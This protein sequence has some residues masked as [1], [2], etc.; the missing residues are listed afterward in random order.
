MEQVVGDEA[1]LGERLERERSRMTH[2]L[3]MQA[4][5]GVLPD[6]ADR[7]RRAR[8]ATA[9]AWMTHIAASVGATW[10]GAPADLG[11]EIDRWFAQNGE[12][13]EVIELDL[14]RRIDDGPIAD[15]EMR[16]R[17]VDLGAAAR[18]LMEG[19]GAVCDPDRDG[20]PGFARRAGARLDDA[21]D[22]IG[23]EVAE[24]RLSA[25]DDQR[26]AESAEL[27]AHVR[28]VVSGLEA[29]LPG[30]PAGPAPSA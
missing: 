6:E 23:S 29:V 14:A 3:F 13:L 22:L 1:G 30:F 11:G 16:R 25:P 10:P 18:W 20:G 24:A 7:R 12:R 9:R 4:E 2:E 19:I 26:V 28:A 15:D 8:A 17:R 5:G 27:F 21:A